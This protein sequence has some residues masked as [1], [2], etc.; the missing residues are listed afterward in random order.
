MTVDISENMD[1]GLCIGVGVGVD[2][3][4]SEG[5]TA[6]FSLKALGNFIYQE[7]LA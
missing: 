6:K 3:G 2:V 4:M 7:D 5:H 1:V